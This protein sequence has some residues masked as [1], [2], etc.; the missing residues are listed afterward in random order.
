MRQLLLLT[1]ATSL[2]ALVLA[3]C[4]S[5]AADAAPT[6]LSGGSDTSFTGEELEIT[7][8]VGTLVIK[9]GPGMQRSV[10]VEEGLAVSKGELDAPELEQTKDGFRIKG[11]EVKVKNCS[12]RNN[13]YELQIKGHSKRPLEDFPVVTVTAPSDIELDLQIIGGKATIGDVSE[14]DLNVSGCGDII[15]GDVADELDASINGSGDIQAGDVGG[16]EAAIRGSGDIFVGQV[17]GAADM[18]IAGSGDIA[19]GRVGGSIEAGIAG[20]GD[21]RSS[22]GTDELDVGIRGSGDVRIQDASFETADLSVAG[23]GDIRV[24]GTVGDLDI[25]IAGSG[26][27]M[28]DKATGEVDVSRVG[29]GDIVVDGKRWT[30][31]GWV[32]D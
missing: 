23:S 5:A 32:A 31:K 28:V 24:G 15:L 3:S 16:L 11:D 19:T 21:I 9:T 18:S 4:S 25:A 20:S 8:F 22:G 10:F 7:D 27:I 13:K 30:R 29:S 17:D 12:S 26:D 1:A 2:S 14:A 6:N